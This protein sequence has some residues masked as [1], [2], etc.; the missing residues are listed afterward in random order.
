MKFLFLLLL[1]LSPMAQAKQLNEGIFAIRSEIL[2]NLL[3]KELCSCL[4]VSGSYERFGKK[5]GLERCYAHASLPISE[6]AVKALV[7]VTVVGENSVRVE[8]GPLAE[9]LALKLDFPPAVAIYHK[10][11]PQYGCSLVF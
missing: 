6:T 3:A 5:D 2:G 1:L 9:A 7:E 8:A 10:D 11:Q 4:F